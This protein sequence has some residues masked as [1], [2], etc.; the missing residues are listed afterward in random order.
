MGNDD[1]RNRAPPTTDPFLYD[2]F[3]TNRLGTQD[4]RDIRQ[5]TRLIERIETQVERDFGTLNI[6][7]CKSDNDRAWN[8]RWG[9]R[10]S[11]SVVSA[12][13][14]ST[15]SATTAEAVGSEPA[16]AP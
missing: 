15:M 13:T 1:N 7:N 3:N 5:H 16:P 6:Q 9:T 12:R 4:P 14:T 2:R 10:L 8:A 11:G